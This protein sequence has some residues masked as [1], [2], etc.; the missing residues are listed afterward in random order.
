MLACP[1]IFSADFWAPIFLH[2]ITHNPSVISSRSKVIENDIFDRFSIRFNPEH[3][4]GIQSVRIGSEAKRNYFEK[5]MAIFTDRPLKINTAPEIFFGELAL[6]L[7]DVDIPIHKVRCLV[8][9]SVS[10]HDCSPLFMSIKES[11]KRPR[12]SSYSTA[13]IT[14]LAV[15]SM[16]SFTDPYPAFDNFNATSSASSAPSIFI[17]GRLYFLEL[18]T[19][20]TE[21]EGLSKKGGGYAR[22]PPSRRPGNHRGRPLAQMSGP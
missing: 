1:M 21:K 3:F 4:K 20:E 22:V 15:Q 9:V 19:G 8:N 12:K 13:V 7:A 5:T 18:A 2:S 16:T 6:M 14:F 17:F 10:I 11:S